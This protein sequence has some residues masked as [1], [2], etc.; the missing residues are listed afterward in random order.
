MSRSVLQLATP[1][2]SS[3]VSK[4]RGEIPDI[5]ISAL[6]PD[7]GIIGIENQIDSVTS[8]TSWPPPLLPQERSFQTAHRA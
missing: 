4:A 8:C 7:W 5:M 1:V 6:C 3:L 2:T